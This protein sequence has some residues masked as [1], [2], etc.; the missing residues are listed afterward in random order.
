MSKQM[1][2]FEQADLVIDRNK[3]RILKY[4]TDALEGNRFLDLARLELKQDPKIMQC[5]QRSILNCIITAGILGLNPGIQQHVHFIPRGRELRIELGFRGLVKLINDSPNL[6]YIDADCV[7]EGEDCTIIKGSHPKLTHSPSFD[8]ERID[9]NIVGAY[10]VL[11]FENTNHAPKF[12]VLSRVEIDNI[13]NA[14]AMK[15]GAPWSKWY[16]EMA[17]KSAIKRLCK[18][19]D[20]SYKVSQAIHVEDSDK[21]TYLT[22]DG[23]V[24]DV[25]DIPDTSP[26]EEASQVEEPKKLT[27]GDKLK[28]KIS[29]G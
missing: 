15:N 11:Y 3:K 21:P 8:S 1:T 4:V 19:I 6:G 12:T 18:Q 7:Y 28:Q 5:S 25:S 14:S 9:A 13:R 22:E 2:S 16:G 20:L 26:A 29:G 10:A 23:K 24:I 17:K 27:Q